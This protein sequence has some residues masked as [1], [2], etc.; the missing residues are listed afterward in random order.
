MTRDE[1][2]KYCK[3]C[4]NRELDL[5]K[6]LVCNLTNEIADFKETCVNFKEDPVKKMELE[7][8][9]SIQEVDSNEKLNNGS[10]WFLWI[11]GLS[12]INT[13]ILYFGGQVSFIFGLGVTQLFEGI[14]ISMLGGFNLLGVIISIL[15]S[16]VFAVIWHFSK[17]L[18]KTAF[19][20]GM[21]LYG[22]D[23]LILLIFQDWLSFGVHLYALFMIFKGFQ[24]IDELKKE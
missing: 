21:V 23:A 8:I 15:I 22:I 19:V 4:L 7:S 2:L 10:Q 9:P 3:I 14:Y 11:F 20:I 1:H 16:G 17:K 6:G 12:A 18:S 24:S 13:L 5:K